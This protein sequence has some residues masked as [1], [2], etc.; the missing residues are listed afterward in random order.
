MSPADEEPLLCKDCCMYSCHEPPPWLYYILFIVAVFCDGGPQ[1]DPPPSLL[2]P[3]RERSVYACTAIRVCMQ[4][5]II[6]PLCFTHCLSYY[7]TFLKT[8]IVVLSSLV[9]AVHTSSSIPYTEKIPRFAAGSMYACMYNYWRGQANPDALH[10]AWM[11]WNGGMICCVVLL[12]TWWGCWQW[13]SVADDEE[14]Q[15]GVPLL[16]LLRINVGRVQY[17]I[18]VWYIHNCR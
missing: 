10:D 18:V 14:E 7:R 12:G 4:M 17:L 2:S 6:W 8:L 5:W 16:G 11:L 1:E 3:K 15:K 13:S 9:N